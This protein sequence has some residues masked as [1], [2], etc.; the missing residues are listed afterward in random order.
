MNPSPAVSPQTSLQ[1]PIGLAEPTGRSQEYIGQ[2]AGR[3]AGKLDYKAGDELIP[4]V[5]ERL[6]GKVEFRSWKEGRVDGAIH[7]R[8]PRDFTIFLSP[9]TGPLRDRFTIAHELGHYFLHSLVG[10]KPIKINREGSGR[11]EWEA[12][13]FAAGFL[14]PEEVFRNMWSD[15]GGRVPALASNFNVSTQTIRIRA[16][17]L[18]LQASDHRG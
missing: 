4:I 12:N 17:V 8:G 16:Q 9:F 7:V 15:T 14:M 5:T 10:E 1:P 3:I 18:G 11:V 2:L 6:G 13:W